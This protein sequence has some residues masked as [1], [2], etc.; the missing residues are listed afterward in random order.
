VNQPSVTGI[1]FNP[2]VKNVNSLLGSDGIIGIKTGN[3]D[4]AGGVFVSASQAAVNNKTVTVITALAT[5]PTLALALKDSVPFIQSTHTNFRSEAVA[6]SSESV[7]SYAL[8][9][10]GTIPVVP[11]QNLIVTTWNDSPVSL[12]VNLKSISNKTSTSASV[13]TLSA[14]QIPTL[15]RQ[16]VSLNLTNAIPQPNVWW[17]LI[18]PLTK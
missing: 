16:S 3:T 18:H 6:Q 13:G 17:R 10:G 4:Q 14:Q 9:W 8:P 7:G 2:I 5:A 15:S 11:T 1:P 12:S